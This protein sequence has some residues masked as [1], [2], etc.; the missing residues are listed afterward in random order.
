MTLTQIT[1]KGIKDGEI[2]NADINAS[3]AIAGTKV[4][5]NFGSQ[6]IV[7]T[8]SITGND[9][10]IDSGTLS[11]DASNNRVGI[12]ETSPDYP[13]HVNSGSANSVAIF[14]ST[15]TAVELEFKDSTGT[16]FLQC[17]ND[18]RLSNSSGE[19]VRIDSSGNVG[20]GTSSPDFDLEVERTG[21]QA[22]DGTTLGVTNTSSD[23]AGLRLNSGHGNW[24]LYNSKTVGDAFEFRDESANSTR[25]LI[26]SSG[27]VLIGT[28]SVGAH[29]G[30]NNFTIAESG[31][32]GMTIRSST[33]TSGN[34]YFADGTSSGESARGEI[35]YRHATDDFRI[36]TAAS[37]K[38]RLDSSGNLLIGTTTLE[39]TTG[40][41]G[42]KIIHTGDIQI[43]GDQKVLL[44]RS[45]NSTAQK[46]SGIQWWNENGAGVQCAIFGVR[47]TVPL[48]KGALAFYTSNN[49]DTGANN[50]EGNITERLR[51]LSGGGI[52]FN[53][54]TATANALND[55][56]EGTWTPSQPTVGMHND[57]SLSGHYQ[58][59]GNF[60]H[61]QLQ[62]RFNSNSSSVAAVIDGFPFTSAESGNNYDYG[63]SI[64]YATRTVGGALIH[65]GGS[66]IN[67]YDTS[68]NNLNCAD[69]SNHY[70][71]I[72]GFVEVT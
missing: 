44:F 22:G 15:D 54:D 13:L 47:E 3:A 14:E 12:N 39:N 10:E 52:T 57:D 18:F 43:D 55:Y 33:S 19:K 1:E 61:F 69:M 26:D 36:F 17:R 25:M 35:S 23:P 37:E 46:Q 59:I 7:T 71:R 4:A 11:V 5:P 65:N 48:A 34:I 53:G 8:G 51:I 64:I 63:G 56:E 42:P 50:S 67:L 9:L 45:T 24:S 41:S 2:I 60:V 29:E 49:V 32:C 31:H 30:G 20:I 21:S 62:C 38:M 27:R 16:A 58:K 40:N 70:V 66:R 6:N 68:G 28:T 72:N